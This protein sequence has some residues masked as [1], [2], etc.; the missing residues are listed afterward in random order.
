M[1]TNS[2]LAPEGFEAV[3]V[4]AGLVRVAE[5]AHGEPRPLPTGRPCSRSGPA[6]PSQ[7]LWWQGPSSVLTVTAESAVACS[8][9]P[10]QAHPRLVLQGQG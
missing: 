6:A 8:M 9:E 7:A 5:P 10:S 3:D 2:K 1:N 4:S